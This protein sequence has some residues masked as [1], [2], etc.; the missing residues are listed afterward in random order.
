MG[1]LYQSRIAE[2]HAYGG[3]CNECATFS[4]EPMARRA[5]NG[6]G[7][8]LLCKGSE[9]TGRVSEANRGERTARSVAATPKPKADRRL[10]LGRNARRRFRIDS[11]RAAA[12]RYL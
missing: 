10:D 12:L 5:A 7:N 6:G 1:N 3:F 11:Q 8:P 9:T 2:K 4:Y